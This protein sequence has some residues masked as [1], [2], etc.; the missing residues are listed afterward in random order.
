ITATRMGGT[1]GSTGGDAAVRMQPMHGGVVGFVKAVAREWYDVACRAVDFEFDASIETIVAG[2]LSELSAADDRIE[3]GYVGGRRVMLQPAPMSIDESA[4][5]VRLDSDSVVLVTGGARGITAEIA[6]EL[7]ERFKPTLVLAGRSPFPSDAEEADTAALDGPRDIKAALAQRMTASG[8]KPTPA[9]IEKAYRQLMQARDMRSTLAAIRQAG[10]RVQYEQIDVTDATGFGALIDRLYEQL[11]RIDGVI[12]GAGVTQDKF[13]RDKTPESFERVI[14]PKVDAALVLAEKLR[15]EALR[16]LVFFSSVSARYGN[17]GQSDYAAAN[18]VLNKLAHTLN[19]AWPARVASLNWGPWESSGGMVSAELAKQFESAGVFMINRPA[20]RRAFVEELLHGRKDDVEVIFGGPLRHAAGEPA[21][22][23]SPA[24]STD[25]PVAVDGLAL[26]SSRTRITR[27]PNGGLEVHRELDTSQDL[28]LLD[29]Q[30]NGKPV[31]PMAMVLEL[32]AEVAAAGW[33]DHTVTGIRELR[34]L[35]G[36]RLDNGAGALRITAEPKTAGDD[37][38]TIDLRVELTGPRPRVCYTA[39]AELRRTA[40]PAAANAPRTELTNARPF[41]MSVSEAYERWLFHGPLFAG[42]E[43]IE[44]IGDN[45]INAKLSPSSPRRC[46]AGA[47]DGDWLIDPVII[48]S[49]LQMLILWARTHLDMT[50]LPSRFGRYHR[51]A[52]KIESDVWCEVRIRSTDESPAIHADLVFRNA[53]G[54][55]VGR[56]ED[57]EVTCSK[58]LNRLSGV[59]AKSTGG[60]E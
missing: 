45:G 51:L 55:V 48:D 28:Y 41:Q 11:G 26:L 13:L 52:A 59:P 34:V 60:R 18:E 38:I 57:M 27:Q 22:A 46:L 7:A 56:L 5:G 30:L 9:V 4:D 20:G 10:A 29:H 23:A 16:F 39:A 47:P 32:L 24:S 36:I 49:G 6:V 33:P 50:P 17:R 42:I 58:A 2:I 44:A 25:Q 37:V 21:T 53:D 15:P 54:A 19:A 12:H 40:P 43:Q 31:M 35:T 1:F 8:E 3:V 14:A